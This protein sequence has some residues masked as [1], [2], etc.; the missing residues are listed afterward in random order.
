MPSPFLLHQIQRPQRMGAKTITEV[1]PLFSSFS[2]TLPLMF[3]IHSKNNVFFIVSFPFSLFFP[4]SPLCI[5]RLIGILVLTFPFILSFCDV[6]CEFFSGWP[7]KSIYV[8][9]AFSCLSRFSFIFLSSCK[10][11]ELDISFLC[12]IQDLGRNYVTCTVIRTTSTML[13]KTL[14]PV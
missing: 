13:S 8:L 7:R 6:P 4:T 12:R 9:I 11:L 2:K 14:N 3:L 5:N 1:T 10:V